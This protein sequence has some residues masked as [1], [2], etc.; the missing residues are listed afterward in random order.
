VGHRHRLGGG[1]RRRHP[2]V[3]LQQHLFPLVRRCRQRRH[4]P[5]GLVGQ[6][7]DLPPPPSPSAR[8]NLPAAPRGGHRRRPVAA[9]SRRLEFAHSQSRVEPFVGSSVGSFGVCSNRPD[10]RQRLRPTPRPRQRLVTTSVCYVKTPAN[11]GGQAGYQKKECPPLD[12]LLDLAYI[13][14]NSTQARAAQLTSNAPSINP[15]RQAQPATKA[16][17]KVA[18]NGRRVP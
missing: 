7:A 1:C 12:N 11:R 10:P 17:R 3:L 4:R 9:V 5:R 13:V 14:P 2:G 15:D 8:L 16:S 18:A 6:L